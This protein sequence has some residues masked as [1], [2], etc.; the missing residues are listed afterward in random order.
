LESFAPQF[1]L[2]RSPFTDSLA[3]EVVS[4]KP[5][6]DMELDEAV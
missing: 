4:F 3:K 6:I 2:I 1:S 5:T